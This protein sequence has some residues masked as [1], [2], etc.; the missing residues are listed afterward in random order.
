MYIKFICYKARWAGPNQFQP[1]RGRLS[2][3]AVG[4]HTIRLRFRILLVPFVW[5]G[6]GSDTWVKDGSLAETFMW[7]S[8]SVNSINTLSS[9]QLHGPII[10]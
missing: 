7:L 6:A 10:S 3:K 9:D 2:G 5:N 4:A 1:P 8:S